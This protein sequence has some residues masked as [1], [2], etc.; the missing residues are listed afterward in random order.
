MPYKRFLSHANRSY[1]KNIKNVFFNNAIKK[2]RIEN[3]EL[4]LIDKV[5]SENE[6]IER[7]VF[8]IKYYKSNDK[9]CGYNLTHGG[10][11]ISGYRH[12]EITKKILRDKKLGS[13]MSDLAKENMK[14]S[15]KKGPANHNYGKRIL[16]H[17][18]VNEKIISCMYDD[19]LTGHF[20]LE[21]IGEKYNISKAQVQRILSG[22]SWPTAQ[23]DTNKLKNIKSV[24]V[25][26]QHKKRK[27]SKLSEDDVLEIRQLLSE[28]AISQT[29]LAKKYNVHIATIS[30]INR[31]R[32][33]KNI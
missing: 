25:S 21:L 20:T 12:T 32:I 31:R 8:W 13:K 5:K 16:T 18:K 3:F 9:K 1:N 29:S 17:S 23:L 11:G 2:Y 19:Y 7:E 24:N 33:W 15:A 26:K 14:K 22:K 28:K 27:Y 10:E 30:A 4:L 6:A